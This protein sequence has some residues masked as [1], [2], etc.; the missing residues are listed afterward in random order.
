[1]IDSPTGYKILYLFAV[2]FYLTTTYLLYRQFYSY[3][4]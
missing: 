1:M 3:N 4:L 2:I